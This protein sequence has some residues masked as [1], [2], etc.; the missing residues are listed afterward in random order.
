LGKHVGL[1]RATPMLLSG[2]A[3]NIAAK[4]FAPIASIATMVGKESRKAYN[5]ATNSEVVINKKRKQRTPLTPSSIDSS[6]GL[7]LSTRQ[8]QLQLKMLNQK[9]DI[10]KRRGA[11]SAVI[12]K[13]EDDILLLIEKNTESCTTIATLSPFDLEDDETTAMV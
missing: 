12:D 5:K 2:V 7:V 13:I 4:T 3:A 8:I 6:A 1:D 9:L 10:M 11:S